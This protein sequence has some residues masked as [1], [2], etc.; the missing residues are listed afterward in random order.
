MIKKNV[1]VLL[2]ISSLPGRHGIGDFSVHAFEFIDSDYRKTNI[3]SKF[4]T[5]EQI[6][7]LKINSKFK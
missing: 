6:Q 4:V 3:I 7:Q 2:P 1:G 5:Q